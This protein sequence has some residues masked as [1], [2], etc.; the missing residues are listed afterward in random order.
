MKEMTDTFTW[1]SVEGEAKGA[2]HE[3]VDFADILRAVGSA[4]CGAQERGSAASSD[5]STNLRDV[6]SASDLDACDGI[7]AQER[8]LDAEWV[9]WADVKRELQRSS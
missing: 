9:D 4:A 3:T 7:L 1:L 2:I 5:S 6:L 8:L